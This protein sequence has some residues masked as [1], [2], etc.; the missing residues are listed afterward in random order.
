[1][2]GPKLVARAWSDP[3]FKDLL[4]RDASAACASLGID[5]SNT[6]AKTVLTVVENTEAVH[7]LVVCTLC[8]CY[9]RSILGLSPDWYKSRSYRARAVLEPRAVLA[10]FG[11]EVPADCRVA[12][13]DSTADL[14]YF[15]LPQRP[16]GTEGWSV[17]ALARLV[18]RDSMIG[19]TRLPDD[20]AAD[21]AP[22]V[23]PSSAPPLDDVAAPS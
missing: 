15:V 18:T 6:T 5:A 14:R 11:T 9:P 13:H 2:V 20:P 22:A 19:V 21:E 7:N 10:E 17:D 3:A 23:T 4:L 16:R 8:S 1:M 12:V